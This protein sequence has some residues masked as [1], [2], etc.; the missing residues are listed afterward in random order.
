VPGPLRREKRQRIKKAPVHDGLVTQYRKPFIQALLAHDLAAIRRERAPPEQTPQTERSKRAE[1]DN[2]EAAIGNQYPIRLAQ[3]L[4]RVR[5]PFQRVG[6]QNRIDTV[7]GYRQ[8][9]GFRAQVS[10]IGPDIQQCAATGPG[11]LEKGVGRAPLPDLQQL[12]PEH[13]LQHLAHYAKL[14]IQQPLAQRPPEPRF[15]I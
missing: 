8:V 6:Q 5:R 9:F 15:E 11:R 10:G 14:Q 7:A 4:M 12:G 13:I 3:N 1:P 2:N